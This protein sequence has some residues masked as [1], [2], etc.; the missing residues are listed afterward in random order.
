MRAL[1]SLA[2]LL[3]ASV[4]ADAHGCA[5]VRSQIVVQSAPVIAVQSYAVAPV[6]AVQS[7]A[8]QQVVQPVFQ[9]VAVEHACFQVASFSVP[10]FQSFAVRDRIIRERVQRVQI[11]ERVQ[12]RE[13]VIERSSFRSR[14]VLRSGY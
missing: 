6:F 3:V 8:V 5:V 2:A 11:R 12:V 1:I 14:S 10:V 4:S 7:Y 9:A 13:R